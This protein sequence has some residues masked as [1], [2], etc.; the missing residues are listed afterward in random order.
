MG[1]CVRFIA[2]KANVNRKS[3]GSYGGR[4]VAAA[5]VA[6]RSY[7]RT[8]RRKHANR[9]AAFPLITFRGVLSFY[10]SMMELLRLLLFFLI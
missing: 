7:V 6:A 9:R 8:A 10:F 4:Y 1:F 5:G 2:Y 3:G